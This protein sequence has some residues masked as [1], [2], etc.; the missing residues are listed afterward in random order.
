MAIFAQIFSMNTGLVILA[1]G[2]SQRMGVPKQLLPVGGI[3]LLKHLTEQAM[4]SPCYPVTIV[5]GAHKDRIQ[6]EL[7]DMPVNIIDNPF[8]ETGMASSIRMG[9]AGTYLVSKE[10]EALI[11]MTSDMPFVNSQYLE[12]LRRTAMEHPDKDIVAS[13]YAETYGI[14]A[15]FR[16]NVLEQLLD[17][18]GDTGAKKIIGDNLSRT[19]FIP[20]EK[21]SIDL[22]TQDDY[23]RF[24]QS[25]N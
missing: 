11:I 15:L 12:L 18:K 5:L 9:L 23:F 24:L 1:A 14:P 19:V 16:R 6:P 17:L 20:F 10:I 8:W 3:S 2:A 7:K 21:G 13:R 4:S 22:D 25:N